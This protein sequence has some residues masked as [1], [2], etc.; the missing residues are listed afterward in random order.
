M[1]ED[2]LGTWT[3]QVHHEQNK[4]TLAYGL[5]LDNAGI[6]KTLPLRRGIKFRDKMVSL[7]SL[8]C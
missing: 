2:R 1:E 5:R 6:P 3:D 7:R 8:S 4:Q